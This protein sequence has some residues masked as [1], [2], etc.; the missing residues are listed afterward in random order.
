MAAWSVGWMVAGTV[1]AVV[2]TLAAVALVWLARKVGA[3]KAAAAPFP[4]L[5]DGQ[6][7]VLFR[8]VPAV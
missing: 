6:G 7:K 1:A 8:Y 2:V 5:P 4:Q 3:M